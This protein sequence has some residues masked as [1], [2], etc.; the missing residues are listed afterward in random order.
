MKWLVQTAFFL[1]FAASVA[2]G[3]ECFVS[4][5]TVDASG[6]PVEGATV[7]AYVP[8]LG[9]ESLI[10]TYRSIEGGEFSVPYDCRSAKAKLYIV[11]PYDSEK[12]FV[13]LRPPFSVSREVAPRLSGKR[14]P[15][16]RTGTYRIGRVVIPEHFQVFVRLIGADGRNLL[17]N[18]HTFDFWLKIGLGKSNWLM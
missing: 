13:P 17:P 2:M 5:I 10:V 15:S 11:A 14:L 7:F 4:G 9:W 1:L 6:R 16:I 3:N 8:P 18:E 12:D